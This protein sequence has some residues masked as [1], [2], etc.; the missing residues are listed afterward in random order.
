M[1]QEN[2]HFKIFYNLQKL[3]LLTNIIYLFGRDNTNLANSNLLTFD[4]N[5]RFGSQSAVR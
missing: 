4:N 2:K 3:L 1:R 5:N